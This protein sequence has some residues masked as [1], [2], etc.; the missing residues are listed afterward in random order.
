LPTKGEF[1]PEWEKGYES[2]G[3]KVTG[4]GKKVG[5]S[6]LSPR[7]RRDRGLRGQQTFFT[8]RVQEAAVER[9]G[10]IHEIEI[11]QGV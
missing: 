10:G 8:E 1:N 2:G 4:R 3:E 9:G 5:G 6:Y 7:L 11:E